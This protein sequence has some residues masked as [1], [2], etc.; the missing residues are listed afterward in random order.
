[1]ES[2]GFELRREAILATLTDDVIKSSEIEG[3]GLDRA[4]VRS[5]IAHRLGMDIAG[6]IHADRNVDGVVEM[7]DQCPKD[8]H[9]PLALV[10]VVFS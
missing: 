6:A 1:M 10:K 9:R 8:S 3:E 5:S 2:L 7:M 4:Q